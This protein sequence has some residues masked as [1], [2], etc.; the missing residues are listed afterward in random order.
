MFGIEPVGAV[1][2]GLASG[3]RY[4]V[5]R[6]DFAD[7]FLVGDDRRRVKQLAPDE[8]AEYMRT[9]H[10]ALRVELSRASSGKLAIRPR[11]DTCGYCDLRPVCRIGAFGV[12]SATS[13]D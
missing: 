13:A 6:S 11:E 10:D 1:Y 5:I 3:E 12:G 2:L 8:F 7:D 4:G 9:R